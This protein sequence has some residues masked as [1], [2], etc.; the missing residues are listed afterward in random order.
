MF[1]VYWTILEEE[2]KTPCSKEFLSSQMV[3]AMQFTE[4]LRARQRGGEGIRFITM[5]SENP[6]VVG[7]AGVADPKPDY[8]WKKRRT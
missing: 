3:E 6:D 8:N 2:K 1:M 7:D 5:C 4:T